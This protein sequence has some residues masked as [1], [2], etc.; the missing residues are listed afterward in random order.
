MNIIRENKGD[1]NVSLTIQIEEADYSPKVEKTLKDYRR[2]A[3]VPGFR[4]GMVPASLI[5]KMYGKT[6]AAEEVNKLISESIEEYIGKEDLKILGQP[7]P[8]Y[9]LN[10]PLDLDNNTSFEFTVDLGLAPEVKVDLKDC[11]TERVII[12]SEDDQVDAMIKSLSQRH[13]DIQD[14]ETAEAGDRLFGS[15]HQLN[16]DGTVK[17][18]GLHSSRSFSPADIADEE[19]RALFVG[20]KKDDF[21][22]FNPLKAAGDESKVAQFLSL[23]K[24][25]MEGVTSDFRFEV[26]SISRNI[27]H[28]V[29]EE[30]YKKAYPK[31]EISNEADFR[32]VVGKTI[33]R[34]FQGQADR[35]FFQEVVK[36]ILDHNKLPMPEDFLRRYAE[37]TITDEH[38]IKTDEDFERFLNGIRWE[39]I[40][41]KILDENEIRVEEPDVRGYT[42]DY[43][44][45]NYFQFMNGIENPEENEY[46]KSSIDKV[47]SDKEQ[48]RRIVDMVIEKKML[49]LFTE[50]FAIKEKH[51]TFK[52]FIESLKPNDSKE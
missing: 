15:F 42:A 21:V 50:K 13:G 24:E 26:E 28:P 34:E 52:Q 23:K 49:Q 39:L 44:I 30:L 27:P 12:D 2:K 3:N 51:L 25:D 16:E 19:T 10:E 48:A 5:K 35:Y 6:I 45:S 18:E 8:N 40:E 31:E 43:L 41:S 7:L 37:A 20:V 4:P 14:V 29:N 9:D 46:I 33:T 38:A 11:G 47:L 32:A 36:S 17:D 1:L 22:T